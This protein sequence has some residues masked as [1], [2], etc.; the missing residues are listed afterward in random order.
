MSDLL[1]RGLR[2]WKKDQHDIRE[3][4][5]WRRM[6]RQGARRRTAL[7]DYEAARSWQRAARNG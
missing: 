3:L 6:V 1:A 2:M 4:R 5:R 7:G